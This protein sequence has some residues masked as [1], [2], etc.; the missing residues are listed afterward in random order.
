MYGCVRPIVCPPKCCVRD[1]YTPRVV[2]VIHPIVNINRQ[3]IVDVPQH[4][5]QPTTT[6]VVV[7]RG[8]QGYQGYPGYAGGMSRR[9][10]F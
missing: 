5:Y 9:L 8:F 3:N 2:P 10:F 6:N 7:N 1:Y 4:I